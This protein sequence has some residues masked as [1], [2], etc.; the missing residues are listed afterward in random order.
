[1]I[2]GLMMTLMMK[3]VMKMM[4]NRKTEYIIFL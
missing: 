3:K 4:M 2:L 1:M